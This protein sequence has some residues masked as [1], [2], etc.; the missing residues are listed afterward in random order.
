MAAMQVVHSPVRGGDE[1]AVTPDPPYVN[2]DD[3]HVQHNTGAR[4]DIP[5]ERLTSGHSSR[6]LY[7]PD[8]PAS[9]AYA[10]RAIKTCT[11]WRDHAKTWF[12]Q[13]EAKFKA[14]N[15]RSTI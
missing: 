3:S 15:V 10:V 9:Q 13:L 8:S 5:A 6:D 1:A 14:H 2:T 11:F 4:A 12:N 7:E